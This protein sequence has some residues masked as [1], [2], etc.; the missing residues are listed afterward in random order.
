MS[1]PLPQLPPSEKHRVIADRFSAFLGRDP[2]W[3]A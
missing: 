3:A 1:T 2:R